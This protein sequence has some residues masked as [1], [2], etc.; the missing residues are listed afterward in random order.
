MAYESMQ[1]YD[2]N[3]NYRNTAI[4][5][6]Y[7]DIYEPAVVVEYDNT[8]EFTLTSKYEHRPDLLAQDLYSNSKLWW[9]FT[10]YNRNKILD[11]IYD[12]VPGL[13][14]RVPNNA[15]SIGV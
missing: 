7:L 6:K 4:G 8:Y 3:S 11:P 14:I 5:K 9:V 13:T 1:K 2:S 15:S 10:L 12:F